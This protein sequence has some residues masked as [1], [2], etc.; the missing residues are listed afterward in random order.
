MR[1]FT[2]PRR[3]YPKQGGGD[4]E[5]PTYYV[6]ETADTIGTSLQVLTGLFWL[7]VYTLSI[8]RAYR[9]KTPAIPALVVPLNVAWELLFTLRYPQDGLQATIN[10]CWLLLDVIIL[11]QTILYLPNRVV[12]GHV[13]IPWSWVMPLLIV[14]WVAIGILFTDSFKDRDGANG[15]FTISIILSLGFVTRALR[16]KSIS[17][18]STY[19][20]LCKLLGNTASSLEYARYLPVMS[21]FHVAFFATFA[22]DVAYFWLIIYRQVQ[23]GLNPWKRL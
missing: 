2:K 22:F 20:A 1:P 17:G 4:H 8:W 12:V 16:T 23:L 14:V 3:Q 18:Q 19:I 21:L 6:N 9:D 13:R 11:L 10:G 5:Q 7:G 15:A